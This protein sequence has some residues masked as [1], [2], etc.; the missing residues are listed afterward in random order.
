MALDTGREDNCRLAMLQM[1]MLV[2]RFAWSFNAELIDP[3]E[4]L[5]EDRFVAR[6]GTLRIHVTPVRSTSE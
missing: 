4:P 5:Y 6:R 1:R 2:A 3:G